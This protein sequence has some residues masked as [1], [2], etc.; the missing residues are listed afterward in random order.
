[1]S[2]STSCSQFLHEQPSGRFQAAVGGV[3]VQASIDSCSACK[4]GVFSDRRQMWPNNEWRLS[5]IRD[6]ISGSF[7]LSFTSALDTLSLGTDKASRFDSN[8][9]SWFDSIGKWQA[10][11]KLSN[12]RACHV[13]RRTINNTQIF[14]PMT[15]AFPCEV[16][17][18]KLWKSVS[19]CKSYSKKL[20]APFFL[21]TV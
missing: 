15:L 17:H 18:K 11:S 1:M 5:A 7:V 20:V 13:C 9:T 10:D 8:R 3:L 12:R 19:I 21:D 4:A 6:G 16:L 2:P 14:M